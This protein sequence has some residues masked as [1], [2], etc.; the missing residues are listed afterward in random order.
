MAILAECSY[1]VVTDQ[2]LFYCR[3]TSVSGRVGGV[4]VPGVCRDCRF[5]TIP[6]SKPRSVPDNLVDIIEQVRKPMPGRPVPPSPRARQATAAPSP[7]RM[8]SLSKQAWNVASSIAAFV[9]DG[10]STVSS[11]EYKTRLDICDTCERRD[12]R[13]CAECGC[14]LA[15]KAKGRAFTCPLGKWPAV[16]GS[17]PS[18][19]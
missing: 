17:K 10:L 8:P 14:V 4:I 18:E 13:R 7:K 2:L 1:R 11:A 9:A 16:V 12:D 15:L 5:R 6:C 3:H 19:P